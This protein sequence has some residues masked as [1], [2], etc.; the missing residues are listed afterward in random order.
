MHYLV[1]LHSMCS[2]ACSYIYVVQCTLAKVDNLRSYILSSSLNLVN[3]A[4]IFSRLL[5]VGISLPTNR[6]L[7]VPDHDLSGSR[8]LGAREDSLSSAGAERPCSLPSWMV[9][10]PENATPNTTYSIQY[11]Q[12]KTA[13]Q[14]SRLKDH[15]LLSK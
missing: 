3:A 6:S 10:T 4:N 12:P 1:L 7:K 14:R 9:V 2:C 11:P 8:S 5:S 15:L 13:K